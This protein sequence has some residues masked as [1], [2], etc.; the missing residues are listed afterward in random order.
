MTE[1]T[2]QGI[3]CAMLSGGVGIMLAMIVHV[4]AHSFGRSPR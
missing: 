1:H 3:V 4:A 2:I